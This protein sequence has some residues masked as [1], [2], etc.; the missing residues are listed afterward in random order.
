MWQIA[1]R[2]LGPDYHRPAEQPAADDP[3]PPY[4]L[5]NS[6][7]RGA[8]IVVAF[9]FETYRW[10]RSQIAA[11]QVNFERQSLANVGYQYVG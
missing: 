10:V 1:G 5:V 4:Y 7:P 2:L 11:T 3:A 6:T 9:E 8:R